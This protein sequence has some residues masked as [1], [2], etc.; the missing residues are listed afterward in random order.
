MSCLTSHPCYVYTHTQ[1][2]K[3]PKLA[4][5]DFKFHYCRDFLTFLT[6][7]EQRRFSHSLRPPAET[8]FVLPFFSATA[9]QSE[10]DGWAEVGEI[11]SVFPPVICTWTW[12]T[13]WRIWDSN[14]H[15]FPT[16]LGIPDCQT[17]QNLTPLVQYWLF[18]CW[19]CCGCCCCC[20][21]DELEMTLWPLTVYDGSA[22]TNWQKFVCCSRGQARSNQPSPSF[23]CCPWWTSVL[24]LQ[25]ENSGWGILFW[26]G[27]ISSQGWQFSLLGLDAQWCCCI[28]YH[29]WSLY[30]KA[31][32]LW[33][34]SG[35][36]KWACWSWLQ[37]SPKLVGFPS[38]WI[39]TTFALSV[40]SWI[41][42]YQS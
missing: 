10:K 18:I 32:Q 8:L 12:E 14:F 24:F 40:W 17:I 13:A 9:Q 33:V 41:G 21:H 29:S 19:F 30:K 26:F 11:F 38:A 6:Q 37:P 20:C 27:D 3:S 16:L 23:F 2:R 4:G 1:A 39:M 15:L 42:K 7:R 22:V 35:S 31:W 34:A 28:C 36:K 25:S 5:I